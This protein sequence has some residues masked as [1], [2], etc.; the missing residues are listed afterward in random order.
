MLNKRNMILIAVI[1]AFMISITNS[2]IADAKSRSHKSKV[3][4]AVTTGAAIGAA[5]SI[6]TGGNAKDTV[7]MAAAGGAIGYIVAKSPKRRA[8]SKRYAGRNRHYRAAAP[9]P[10]ANAYG[11]RKSSYRAGHTAYKSAAYSHHRRHHKRWRRR[12]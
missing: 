8:S 2:G 11:A 3:K 7:G 9:A 6:L 4:K 10:H 12:R 1:A 5:V